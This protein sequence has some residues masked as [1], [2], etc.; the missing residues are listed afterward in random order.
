MCSPHV[1]HLS[2][3]PFRLWQ[4]NMS[5]SPFIKPKVKRR[6]ASNCNQRCLVAEQMDSRYEAAY[7]EWL[8]KEN[9]QFYVAKEGWQRTLNKYST[10]L[11]LVYKGLP[12]AKVMPQQSEWKKIYKDNLFELYARP[13]LILPVVDRTGR[14]FAGTFP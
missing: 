3:P 5:F 4:G 9:V 7:P 13:C 6:F 12:L 8:V 2:I 14:V 11:V 1:A 10:D